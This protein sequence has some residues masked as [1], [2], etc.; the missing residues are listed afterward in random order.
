MVATGAPTINNVLTVLGNFEDKKGGGGC[1]EL[2]S[3]M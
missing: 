2:I 1:K 3:H